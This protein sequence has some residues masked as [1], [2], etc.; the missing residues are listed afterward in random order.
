MKKQLYEMVIDSVKKHSKD[1]QERKKFFVIQ[2]NEVIDMMGWR[3]D[4]ALDVEKRFMMI[5]KIKN[6]IQEKI[7]GA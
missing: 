7:E 1:E 6:L 4:Y 3:E 2:M 5:E